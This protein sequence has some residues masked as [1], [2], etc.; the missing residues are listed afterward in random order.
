MA[1]VV[2]VVGAVAAPG[3][4]CCRSC[5]G[6]VKLFVVGVLNFLVGVGIFGVL[7]VCAPFGAT[8][9]AL[10]LLVWVLGVFRAWWI[11]V[12]CIL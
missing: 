8:F 6:Y 10:M 11:S 2:C 1:G 9:T 12:Y 3:Q 4:R 5:C 7:G